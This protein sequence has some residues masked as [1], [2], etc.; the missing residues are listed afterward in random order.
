MFRLREL[1]RKDLLAINKWRN[2]P[3]LISLLGAP[4]RYINLDVDVKWYESY[5]GNRGNAVRCA[6]T[7]DDKDEILGLVSLV[8][9]NYM[10]Q[11]AEFHIMIGDTKNQGR[12]I[13]TFAVNTMLNHAFNNMNLQ[14]VELTVLE[15]NT[16]AR[17]LYEKCGFVYEGKKRKAKYK[18]GKFVDMLIYSILKS[19]FYGGGVIPNLP[20]WQILDISEKFSIG[21]IIDECDSAFDNPVTGRNSY[22]KLLEKIHQKGRFIFAYNGSP[23]G[24]CAFYANDTEQKRAYISLIAVAPKYQKMHIGAGLL[25]ESFEIMRTY[26]MQYCLLEVRKNNINAIQFYERNQFIMVDER[27]ESYLMKCKL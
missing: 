16:R 20:A 9:I 11:S 14:R 18:N 19:E 7:E 10:N 22:L 21:T 17:H 5:M 4:F 27:A 12:G 8:S 13:G 3:E 2:D 15:D 24:Y 23:L 6:I 1:E 26:G 25:R